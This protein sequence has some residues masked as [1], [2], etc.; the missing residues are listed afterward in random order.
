MIEWIDNLVETVAGRKI[1]KHYL[2]FFRYLICGGFA[3]LTDAGALFVLTHYFAAHYLFAAGFSYLCGISVNYTLNTK[4]VFKSS[5]KYHREIPIFVLIG[6]GGLLWTEVIMWLLVGK[7][8]I[9]VMFAKAAAI[10][11]VLMWNF[12]MRKKFVFTEEPVST[13]DVSF[14]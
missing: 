1:G 6:L 3:T 12:F 4:L 8:K 9:Y 10:I 5:G 11:F 7:L 13:D 2:Q 14:Y